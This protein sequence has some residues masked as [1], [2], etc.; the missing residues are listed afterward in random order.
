[1]DSV[2]LPEWFTALAETSAVIVALFLPRY[3][4]HRAR[5]A[6]LARMRRVTKGMLATLARDRAAC[7]DGC[8]PAQLE[9]AKGLELY[10]RVAF[11]AL[12]DQRELDLRDEVARLYRA[13]VAPDADVPALEREIARL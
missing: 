13:L 7:G 1:M 12:S 3:Q 2:S 4:E 10:L 9:S 11:F 8:D 5:K 6:S